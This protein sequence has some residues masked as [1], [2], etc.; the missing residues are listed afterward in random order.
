MSIAH[1]DK[2]PLRY[3]ALGLWN[4]YFIAKFI[5]FFR[6][7]IEF[8]VLENAT[9][10]FFLLIPTNLRVLR[11]L[12]TV[13]AIVLASLL[14][15]YDSYLPPLTRLILHSDLLT[16]FSFTYIIE[17]VGRF[18]SWQFTLIIVLVFVT[19][20]LLVKWIRFTTIS[21]LGITIIAVAN[22]PQSDSTDTAVAMTKTTNTVID[23]SIATVEESLTRFY[24]EQSNLMTSFPSQ[25]KGADF[26]VVLL[27]ICSLAWADINKSNLEFDSF[28]AKFDILFKNFSSAASYSGP[29]AVR[30]LQASCGQRPYE[31]L[32]DDNSAQCYL[33]EN[34]RN[35]GF[36]VDFAMNH[37]GHFDNFLGLVQDKGKLNISLQSFN[38][39]RVVQKAFDD[40]SIYSD[41][42]VLDQ[43][44]ASKETS[45]TRSFF[46]YNSISLHD[47]NQLIGKKRFSDSLKSYAVRSKLLI[48]DL[49][50]FFKK[51]EQ[52][53]RNYM[54]MMV[55][56][57]GAFLGGDKMQIEGMRD[58]PNP[59][60]LNVPVGIKFFGP[61][62]PVNRQQQ[63]VIEPSSYLAVSELVSR[64]L[65]QDLF[66]GTL[67]LQFLV[68][69]L[70][71]TQMVGEHAGTRMQMFNGK[72]YIQ[73]DDGEWMVYPGY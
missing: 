15:H 29:A 44:L 60:I 50:L 20:T 41:I 52:S 48:A 31:E 39:A 24:Q 51:L 4:L 53:R 57:H 3:D 12:K 19:Y 73:L 33:A 21:V 36:G 25:F 27:N 42:D 58:I 5:L 55:P 61:K 54:V 64:A 13:T 32:Y 18:I 71:T 68:K 70:P 43:W 72:P 28:F 66:D 10:V 37:D 63:I 35:L 22:L 14:L 30:V 7:N 49:N 17:L 9:F 1:P 38:A 6:G 11:T 8:H 56:E 45:Q 69:D 47:G 26:D 65:K 2:D 59:A 16:Q 23:S 67:N 40:S 34:L 62:L 46:Y